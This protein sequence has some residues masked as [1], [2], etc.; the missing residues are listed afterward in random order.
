MAISFN[1]FAKKKKEELIPASGYGSQYAQNPTNYGSSST[2]IAQSLSQGKGLP[3]ITGQSLSVPSFQQKQQQVQSITSQ[4]NQPFKKREVAGPPYAG[5]VKKEEKTSTSNIPSYITGYETLADRQKA[6]LEQQKKQG[7]DYYGKS[8]NEINRLLQESIPSLQQQFI[9]TQG[10]IQKGIDSATQ[11]AEFKKQGA[12]DEWGENQRL[13][14]QTRRESEQRERNR[15]A[16]LGTTDS[17][18]AGSYG[19]AQENVESDFNRFTQEG[20]R[21]KEQ[22]RFEIDRALQ[23]Y[24]IE[25]QTIIDVLEAQLN[26]TVSQIQSDM[27][28]NNI[29]KQNALDSLFGDYQAKVLQV[30]E[31]MQGVY[32]DYYKA[33]ESAEANSLSDVFMQ[34]GQPQTEADFKYMTENYEAL[35]KMK[36]PQGGQNQG[37]ALSLVNSLLQ[38]N[39]EAVSGGFRTPGIIAPLVPG[40]AAARADYEGIKNLLS[41][42][43]R[44]QLKGSGAV[45]DFEARMLEKA[46]LAGLSTELPEDEFIRRLQFLKAD[47]EAGGA[48]APERNVERPSLSSFEG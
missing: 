39:T 9:K 16:A 2:N 27:R 1:P 14:A 33:L 5:P 31:G 10:N 21:S 44:G 20:L 17:W 34:T 7:E 45:S 28:M 6:L 19:Q 46:A 47:L 18:G 22:N 8:H 26:N 24:E 29:E 3:S 32:A 42:A 13:A 41:L 48:V 30:E 36:S 11:S 35:E 43:E 37:K 40:A 23:D 15:F 25:A 4:A 38:G 12:E